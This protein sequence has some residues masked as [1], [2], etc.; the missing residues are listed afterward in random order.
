MT[1]IQ[2]FSLSALRKSGEDPYKG[3]ISAV[4]RDGE[5]VGTVLDGAVLEAQ[6]EIGGAFLLLVSDDCPYEETL[7]AYLIDEQGKV[8]DRADLGYAY[9]SGV[10]RNIKVTGED[11]LEFEFTGSSLYRLVVHSRPRRFWNASGGAGE[12]LRFPAGRRI[13]IT[14][15]ASHG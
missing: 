11:T 15:E 5:P 8:L 12:I 4:L 3:P 7:H 10:L 14:R 6:Y 13:Q 1:P 9:T 2:R